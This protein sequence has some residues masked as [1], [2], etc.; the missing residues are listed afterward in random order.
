MSPHRGQATPEGQRSFSKYSRQASSF[1]KRSI[2]LTRLT[3]AVMAQTPKKKK[4]KL[5]KDITERP[6]REVMEKL[7][8]KRVLKE[9]E[10]I[11]KP[12]ENKGE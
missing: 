11:T 5:P 10:K 8:G 7:F 12:I 6:D 2:K 9:V 3:L 4:R 1:G